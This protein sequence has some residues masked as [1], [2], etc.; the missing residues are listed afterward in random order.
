MLFGYYKNIQID[1][2]ILR[3]TIREEQMEKSNFIVA[4]EFK[5]HIF[6]LGMGVAEYFKWNIFLDS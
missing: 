5:I 3:G 6:C 1:I 4:G 2:K